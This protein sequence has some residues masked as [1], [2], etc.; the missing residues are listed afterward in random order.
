MK[1][2]EPLWAAGFVLLAVAGNVLAFTHVRPY[3]NQ[4]A[5]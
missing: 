4:S 2:S 3:P 1:Y 5:Q